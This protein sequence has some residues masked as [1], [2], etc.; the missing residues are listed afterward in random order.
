[1]IGGVGVRTI[2]T[3]LRPSGVTDSGSCAGAAVAASARQTAAAVRVNP[4]TVGT[5]RLLL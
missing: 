5:R 4:L 3:V 1:M 2:W